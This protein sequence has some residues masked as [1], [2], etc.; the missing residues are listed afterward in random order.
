[1]MDEDSSI[2]VHPSKIVP[3]QLDRNVPFEQHGHSVFPR[4][5]IKRKSIEELAAEKASE[6][7]TWKYLR[8]KFSCSKGEAQRK[9][10]Y[11][12]STGMLFTAQDLID[13]GLDLPSTFGNRKPQRYYAR[14]MK[15]DI[16]EEIKKEVKNV[17]VHPT[18]IT[19]SKYPLSNQLE[20]QKAQS[21]V[22]VLSSLGGYSLYIHR[23][24]LQLSIAPE[25]Y[26][27]STTITALPQTKR[28]K[29]KQYL[30]RMARAD[31][32]FVIYPNGKIMISVAC[33]NSPFKL[34]TDEDE[35]TLFSFLGQIRDRL[36]YIVNDPRERAIPNIMEWRLS[37][38]DI[39]KDIEISD[40][41]QLSS[42]DIQLNCADRVFRL[43]VKSLHDK[44]VYRCEE[45]LAFKY[46]PLVEALD[47]IRNPNKILESKFDMMLV[48]I[49]QLRQ[50]VDSIPYCKS[51]GYCDINN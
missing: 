46:T 33:S 29:G 38:C 34:E 13:Q 45:S 20:L 4:K 41:V 36:L 24:H 50:K 48:L 6:G 39:N 2:T 26:H 47:K 49:N 5:Y 15:A 27:T 19:I 22:D 23:L 9:L 21:L 40:M 30:E 44:A 18:G 42:I 43:Y 8:D 51:I 12:H 16:I 35:S 28:N 7:I 1:M 14:S 17:L 32:N 10:K 11:F 3:M 25:Y 37:G 31:V